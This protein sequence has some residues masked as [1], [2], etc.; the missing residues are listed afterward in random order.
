MFMLCDDDAAFEKARFGRVV[1]IVNTATDMSMSSEMWDGADGFGNL[2]PRS[3]TMQ[4]VA[5][6][7]FIDDLMINA[8]LQE[9]YC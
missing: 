2:E 6:S 5:F 9:S 1:D 8:A 4:N 3:F 7:P